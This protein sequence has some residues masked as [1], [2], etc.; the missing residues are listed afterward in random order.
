MIN[1]IITIAYG[2]VLRVDVDRYV[3]EGGREYCFRVL[4]Q[5]CSWGQKKVKYTCQK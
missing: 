5:R 4:Y 2:P 1:E 3:M